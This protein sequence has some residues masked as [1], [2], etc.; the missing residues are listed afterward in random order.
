ML[1]AGPN[2][3]AA[4]DDTISLRDDHPISSSLGFQAG[5]LPHLIIVGPGTPMISTAWQS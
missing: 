5:P 1:G 4:V 3:D 2:P